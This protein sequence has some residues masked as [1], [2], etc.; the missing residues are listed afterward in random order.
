MCHRFGLLLGHRFGLPMFG[1]VGLRR[2]GFYIRVHREFLESQLLKQKIEVP[3]KFGRTM[4][5]I[6]DETNCLDYGEIFVQ[7]SERAMKAQK[8]KIIL[9]GRGVDSQ[10]TTGSLPAP[11]TTPSSAYLLGFV[12]INSLHLSVLRGA[13][14]STPQRQTA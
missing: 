4:Y 2:F 5:G 1:L 3:D 12:R 13:R 6:L 10:S 9:K 11:T 8:K 7:Y 14:E